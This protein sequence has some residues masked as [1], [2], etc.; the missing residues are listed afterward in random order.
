MQ[1]QA[2]RKASGKADPSSKPKPKRFSFDKSK[3]S[4][5]PANVPAVPGLDA[6]QNMDFSGMQTMMDEM[7][8][9]LTPEAKQQIEQ[10]TQSLMSGNAAEGAENDHA[11]RRLL[12][13]S[14][15]RVEGLE[16]QLPAAPPAAA[17]RD[18]AAGVGGAAAAPHL[19]AARGHAATGRR[20]RLD[21]RAY[22]GDARSRRTKRCG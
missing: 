21:G 3:Q 20:H 18:A 6:L 19:D 15:L 10:L 9:S 4:S 5:P 1:A 16:G 7:M 2:A 22:A 11:R 14:P 17:N 13:R 12:G 8:S